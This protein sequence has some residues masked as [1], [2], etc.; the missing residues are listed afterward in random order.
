MV[1]EG[2]RHAGPS[3]HLR[4]QRPLILKEWNHG[5]GAVWEANPNYRKGEP[6]IDR[7]EMREITDSQI[8]FQA[9]K[10]GELDWWP[11]PPKT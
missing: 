10:E 4:R 5:S 7:I 9:Y 2:R 3:R 11:S 8:A 6:K 1:D